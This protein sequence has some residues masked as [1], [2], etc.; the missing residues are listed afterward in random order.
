[1]DCSGRRGAAAW[2]R[3]R[4]QRAS[5]HPAVTVA[6]VGSQWGAAPCAA[7]LLFVLIR[8]RW[9]PCDAVCNVGSHSAGKG[10][11]VRP[12][13]LRPMRHPTMPRAMRPPLLLLAVVS[14][15]SLLLLCSLAA[16]HAQEVGSGGN[17][18]QPEVPLTEDQVVIEEKE[19]DNAHPFLEVYGQTHTSR[20]GATDALSTIRLRRAVQQSNTKPIDRCAMY[21]C[22]I[23]RSAERIMVQGTNATPHSAAAETATRTER[24][25]APTCAMRS[26]R[27]TGRE[28]RA[29]CNSVSRG[30][31]SEAQRNCRVAG[32]EQQ[33]EQRL[34]PALRAAAATHTLHRFGF[35]A[36]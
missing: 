5:M 33:Q 23:H 32:H 30:V 6:R 13:P 36:A 35:V 14:L 11:V 17:S 19:D 22:T 25:S 20:H 10:T 24:D 27:L 15:C 18:T 3:D 8:L 28:Q 16:V 26:L 4:A 1:M 34:G 9:A 12:S 31:H 2:Q 29:R 21:H 7:R